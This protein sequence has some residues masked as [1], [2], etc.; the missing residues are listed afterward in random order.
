MD[1]DWETVKRVGDTAIKKWIADSDER[2]HLLVGLDTANREWIDHEI[3]RSW[4]D[5]MGA[6][7]F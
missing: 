3:V 2:P 7:G 4:D 6:V 5:G 1:N